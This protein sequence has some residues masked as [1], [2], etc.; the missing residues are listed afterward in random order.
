MKS[1]FGCRRRNNFSNRA[2]FGGGSNSGNMG[3]FE[4]FEHAK[5]SAKIK[6]EEEEKLRLLSGEKRSIGDILTIILGIIGYM[7]PYYCIISVLHFIST[8]TFN[9]FN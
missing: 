9:L 3:F 6:V 5:V 1:G 4:S 7:F 8:G 2:N